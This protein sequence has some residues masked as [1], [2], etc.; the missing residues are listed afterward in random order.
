MSRDDDS[1]TH[2]KELWLWKLAG[3]EKPAGEW[4]REAGQGMRPT[5]SLAAG[6]SGYTLADRATWA[7]FKNRGSL[8]ILAERDAAL[9]NLYGSILVNPAKGAHIKA[10][11]A[12]TWHEWLTSEAGRK[13][14]ASFK[15]GGEQIFF[16]AGTSPRG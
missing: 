11:D 8:E 15:V 13:A 2:R 12:R 9:V 10:A 14:I 4:Y 7:S 3:V 1:G 6:L 16:P 5:L